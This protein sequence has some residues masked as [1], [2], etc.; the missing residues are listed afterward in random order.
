MS[1]KNLDYL[2]S[3]DLLLGSISNLS[4]PYRSIIDPIRLL[5]LSSAGTCMMV[6][7]TSERFRYYKVQVLTVTTCKTNNTNTIPYSFS[8][9]DGCLFLWLVWVV[10]AGL[11]VVGS[12]LTVRPW[13]PPYIARRCP[14]GVRWVVRWYFGLDR[15]HRTKSHRTRKLPPY[16]V[17]WVCA[18][19]RFPCTVGHVRWK[20]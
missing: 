7:Q 3:L 16:I 20:K 9:V 2:S 12:L 1:L 19:L 10:V 14:V 11:L 18:V 8:L 15:K 17:R 4:I 13:T 5:I 6:F